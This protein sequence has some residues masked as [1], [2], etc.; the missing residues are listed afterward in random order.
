M[1]EVQAAER[2]KSAM[3][4]YTRLRSTAGPQIK[5]KLL[6]LCSE[7]GR[8]C[9]A[10]LPA[11]ADGHVTEQ[12]CSPSLLAALW[13]ELSF[14]ETVSTAAALDEEVNGLVASHQEQAVTLELRTSELEESQ[15]ELEAVS[16][17]R[18]DLQLAV[19]KQEA[20][21]KEV[22]CRLEIS[23]A[24]CEDLRERFAQLGMSPT[25]SEPRSPQ[26]PE[27][28]QREELKKSIT[29]KIAAMLRGWML[30]RRVTLMREL[31]HD[32]Y[33]DHQII[34]GALQ[35]RTIRQQTTEL[36]NS[37]EAS[38]A[39]RI[40]G[41]IRGRSAT[42]ETR[43]LSAELE[44]LLD[45]AEAEDVEA[46]MKETKLGQSCD[47]LLSEVHAAIKLAHTATLKASKDALAIASKTRRA[48]DASK[49]RSYY[50]VHVQ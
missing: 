19:E 23:E 44:G 38:A 40:Q 35:G 46:E 25:P 37:Q 6:S 21:T 48:L 50:A 33:G 34:L 9:C 22:L 15:A 16:K 4:L 36:R 3:A 10:S 17:Q 28:M 11:T 14:S 18:D 49:S 5:E 32:D 31:D 1:D 7:D 29:P 12:E 8:E 30:R 2:V 20:D 27:E 13:I 42:L 43:V 41:S 39:A 45:E 47:V 24:T 26:T